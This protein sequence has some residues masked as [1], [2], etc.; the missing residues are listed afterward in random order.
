MAA[1]GIGVELVVSG[2]QNPVT[3]RRGLSSGLVPGAPAQSCVPGAVGPRAVLARPAVA[4][5]EMAGGTG[6]A[7]AGN[8]DPQHK[9][10]ITFFLDQLSDLVG[11]A[12]GKNQGT[13]GFCSG[14]H[15]TTP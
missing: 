14:I 4:D 10:F 13:H 9:V 12:V 2:R 1:Q 15:V 8:K 11:R 3:G 5:A 6:T 7:A